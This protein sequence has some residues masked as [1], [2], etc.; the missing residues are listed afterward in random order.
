M[1]HHIVYIKYK[2]GYDQSIHRHGKTFC[3]TVQKEIAGVISAHYAENRF[4][5]FSMPHLGKDFTKGYTHVLAT[6][7]DNARALKRYRASKAHA[8]FV[9]HLN[10]VMAEFAICD[11]QTR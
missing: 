3:R 7:F 9:P 10:A 6:T 5:K 4:D 1:L 8:I 11:F 2:R